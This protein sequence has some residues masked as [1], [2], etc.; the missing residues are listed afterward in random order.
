MYIYICV[1]IY[2]YALFLLRQY[3]VM[4]P[5]VAVI[6]W[7]SPNGVTFCNFSGTTRQFSSHTSLTSCD[8][9][10]DTKR[11]FF[12][13]VLSNLH[14]FLKGFF[15]SSNFSINQSPQKIWGMVN[16]KGSQ[17]SGVPRKALHL[18][19]WPSPGLLLLGHA[20]R[21]IFLLF[22]FPIFFSVLPNGFA[23]F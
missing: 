13:L 23:R 16:P 6:F 22:A 15:Q 7:P 8:H 4:L 5:H 17:G 10:S 9:S 3:C 11:R 20:I 2:I 12:F 14:P 18:W 1:S 19:W 21:G